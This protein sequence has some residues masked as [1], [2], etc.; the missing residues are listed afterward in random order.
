[1]TETATAKGLY[2]ADL[3]ESGTV[4]FQAACVQKQSRM[5]RKGRPKPYLCLTLQDRTGEIEARIWD[6]VEDLSREFEA[7]SIVKIQGDI[8]VWDGERQIVVTRIRRAEAHEITLGDFLPTTKCD[9]DAMVVALDRWI[10]T[11]EDGAVRHLLDE[12]VTAYHDDLK[13]SPAAMRMHHAYVGGLLEHILS[14]IGAADSLCGHYERLNR[15]LLIAGCILH[16][17]GKVFE[18]RVGLTFEHTTCG[19]LV[20]HIADGV[21]LIERHAPPDMDPRTKELLMHLVLSHHGQH[22]YGAPVLPVT[23][24]AIALHFIDNL[25][26]KLNQAWTAI[27]AASGDAE[28]TEHVR[29]LGRQLYCG[30]REQNGG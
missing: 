2:I 10:S 27:D 30:R 21:L 14:M 26:A 23:P 16:D 4:T 28:W 29:G 3:P 9:V 18:F 6:N 24:E 20:G 25:D 11:V 7:G 12:I 1:M 22:D 8:S 5:T 15:D 13:R 17:L 19:R